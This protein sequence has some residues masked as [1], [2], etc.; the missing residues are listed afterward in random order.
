[1]DINHL[2]LA[3][4]N[5]EESRKFYETY[6]GFKERTFHG[7]CL[8]LANEDGFDLALDP[9]FAPEELPKWFHIGL[10]MKTAEE[11]KLL[12]A[13]LKNEPQF[14]I[15]EIQEYSD[16]IFFHMRDVDGYKLEVYW[17]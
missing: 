17:E 16:F 13:K 5:L 4:K 12:Y 8:F 9:E 11:V 2:H 10:R 6:L 7:N 3:V 1:M 14:I 15:R